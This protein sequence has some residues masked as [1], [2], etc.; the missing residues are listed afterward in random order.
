MKLSDVLMWKVPE[1]KPSNSVSKQRARLEKDL[2]S[3]LEQRRI[4]R[5][6]ADKAVKA[7]ADYEA[8]VGVEGDEE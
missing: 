1:M 8:R 6:A 5:E 7:M 3:A 4:T 2:A